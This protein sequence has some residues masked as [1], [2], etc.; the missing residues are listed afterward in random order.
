MTIIYHNDPSLAA[1]ITEQMLAH[2][3]ADQVFGGEY[4]D[5]SLV[6][7]LTVVMCP[8]SSS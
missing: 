6:V 1:R 4:W 2:H 5:A 7:S 3:A 8:A